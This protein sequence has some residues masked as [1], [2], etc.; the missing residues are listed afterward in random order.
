MAAID[1]KSGKTIWT[2]APIDDDMAA[3]ASPIL[4]SYAG[5]RVLAHCS[6]AHGLGID[7]DTGK[8]LW[9]VPLKNRFG[10]NVST[11]IYGWGQVFYVTPY[12][13]LGRAY[14]LVAND[15]SIEAEHIWTNPLDTVTGCGLLIGRKL[16]AAGYRKPKF[17]CLVDW[18]SGKTLQEIK[19]LT[20]G[21]AIM[22][23]RRVYLLDER[24]NAA[25]LKPTPKSMEIVSRF[26][27]PLDGKRVSDAWAHPV[28]CDGRLYL[29]YHDK[30]WCY[31]VKRH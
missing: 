20:T 29:R 9:S 1:K 23:D 14:R 31:D 8:L 19:D 22:A 17:W 25:L 10:T 3:H 13:D 21:A 15:R 6:S 18:Q 4:F 26:R 11:P 27:L 30:L 12:T 24:G 28:L 16:F 5:H 2:T 7:A